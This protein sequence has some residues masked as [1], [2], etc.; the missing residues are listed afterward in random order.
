M[1]GTGRPSIVGFSF[2]RVFLL[3][4]CSFKPAELTFVYDALLAQQALHVGHPLIEVHQ[5]VLAPFQKVRAEP[6]VYLLAGS[7]QHANTSK[8]S[9]SIRHV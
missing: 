5:V 8:P 1:Q 3:V 6:V 4:R 9:N 2:N 7:P